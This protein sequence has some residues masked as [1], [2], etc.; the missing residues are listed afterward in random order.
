MDAAQVPRPAYSMIPILSP[1]TGLDAEYRSI[2][3]FPIFICQSPVTHRLTTTG[4]LFPFIRR[5]ASVIFFSLTSLP[6][7]PSSP[8]RLYPDLLS[9]PYP[10][11][12]ASLM[13]IHRLIPMS[14]I[15]LFYISPSLLLVFFFYHILF[16]FFLFLI[17]ISIF[18]CFILCVCGKVYLTL[19]TLG[20]L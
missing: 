8:R 1:L 4:E 3:F 20:S 5:A 14:Y 7:T 11:S 13:V 15:L 17:D 12:S 10:S 9:L 19:T 18:Y 2:P 6:S 16:F